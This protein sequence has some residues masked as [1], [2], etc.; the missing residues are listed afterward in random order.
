MLKTLHLA[1][2]IALVNLIVVHPI[3]FIPSLPLL[4]ALTASV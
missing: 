1:M 4:M 3:W 2:V